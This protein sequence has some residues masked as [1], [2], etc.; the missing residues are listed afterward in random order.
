MNDDH[1]MTRRQYREEQNK[2][3]QTELRSSSHYDQ[4]LNHGNGDQNMDESPLLSSQH[5]ENKADQVENNG[6]LTRHQTLEEDKETLALEKTQRLKNKLN[7]I[8]IGLIVAIILVYLFLFF[9]G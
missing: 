1:Q 3:N 2:V 7:K 8:I 9:V 4:W 6:D 5:Q